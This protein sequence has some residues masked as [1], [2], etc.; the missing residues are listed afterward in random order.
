[1]TNRR[2]DAGDIFNCSLGTG[3]GASARVGPAKSG[4]ILQFDVA[5]HRGGQMFYGVGGNNDLFFLCTGYEVFDGYPEQQ[6]L[7]KRGKYLMAE[8]EGPM[9]IGFAPFWKRKEKKDRCHLYQIDVVAALLFSL[10]LGFNP[11]ELV[12]FGL[13]WFGPDILGDDIESKNEKIEQPDG[14]YQS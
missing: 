4:L 12:D 2:R 5:G 13:G 1:M 7:E 11:A 3:L 8:W 14:G 10:R 9:F 6:K